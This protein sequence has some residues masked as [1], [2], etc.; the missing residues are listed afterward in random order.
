MAA[1]EA[2]AEA[3]PPKKGKKK[4]III[5]AALVV[6]LG[7]GGAAALVIMKKKAAAADEGGDAKSAQAEAPKFKAP[8]PKNPPIFV[9]LEPFTVNLKPEP[10]LGDKFAQISVTLEVSAKEVEDALKLRMPILRNEI[11]FAIA[12]KTAAQLLTNEGKQTLGLDIAA[13]AG[14]QLGWQAPPK[15]VPPPQL[16]P[17]PGMTPEQVAQLDQMKAMLEKQHREQFKGGTPN[18]VLA[19]HFASFIVH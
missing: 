11:L 14:K 17:Q 1:K 12:D 7:G 9:S 15:F 13:A 5:V 16:L 10:G 2:P 4:L 8:D 6:L 3:A 19:V 18:P